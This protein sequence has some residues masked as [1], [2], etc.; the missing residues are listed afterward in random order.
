[1]ISTRLTSKIINGTNSRRI[2]NK[3]VAQIEYDDIFCGSG[4]IISLKHVITDPSVVN[5]LPTPNVVR[6]GS[7]LV[8]SG[9]KYKIDFIKYGR[10]YNDQDQDP[11]ASF[12]IIYVS[13][14]I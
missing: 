5:E 12:A 13:N 3:H 11:D 2:Y 8:D 1:M 7:L 10:G 6:A 4:A 14:S 9:K